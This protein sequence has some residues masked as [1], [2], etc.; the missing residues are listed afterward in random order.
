MLGGAH[1]IS[2]ASS[3]PGLGQRG[4]PCRFPGFLNCRGALPVLQ[5]LS[6]GETRPPTTSRSGQA[7]VMPNALSVSDRLEAAPNFMRCSTEL[8]SQCVH[9]LSVALYHILVFAL[10]SGWLSTRSIASLQ[11]LALAAPRLRVL[12]AALGALSQAFRLA[13]L[14]SGA[15]ERQWASSD[16]QGAV[17]R[18]AP[19]IFNDFHCPTGRNLSTRRP[20]FSAR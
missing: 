11:P 10:I 16:H 14:F 8:P 1:L 3:S 12:P 6:S 19:W 9:A 20:R 15:A 7:V 17:Q 18:P 2:A 5:G 4:F 13:S